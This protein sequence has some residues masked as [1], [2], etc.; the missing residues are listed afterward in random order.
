L[1]L[2]PADLANPIQP[3]AASALSFT[4]GALLPLLAILLPPPGWRVPT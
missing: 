2:D 1:H 4:I 3:A